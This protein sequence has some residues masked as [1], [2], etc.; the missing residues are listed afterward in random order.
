MALRGHENDKEHADPP[1]NQEM[2]TFM[3]NLQAMM[4]ANEAMMRDLKIDLE[5]KMESQR[6]QT[7][8]NLRQYL[9]EI[10]PAQGG[11]DVAMDDVEVPPPPLG[12][13]NI[14][15]R[16][17]PILPIEEVADNVN[18]V[19]RDE[20][21]AYV[22]PRVRG[23]GAGNG[24][25]GNHNGHGHNGGRNGGNGNANGTS[26][27]LST[28]EHLGRFPIQCG[29]ANTGFQ[30]LRL[31]PNSLT[32][33]AFTWYINLPPN[34]VTT[35]EEMERLFH[36]QFYKTEPEISMVDLSRLSQRKGE[37]AED[38][39]ARFKKMRNRCRIALP[40]QEFVR[41]A[42]NGLDLELRKKFEGMEFRDYYEMSTKVARY[43]R[44]LHEEMERRSSSYGTYY[45]EPNYEL[46]VAEIK[47]DRPIECPAL[48]SD[49]FDYLYKSG[50]VKLPP[51]HNIPYLEIIKGKEYCK[52]HDSW[53]HSTN[54][55]TVFRNI[56]QEKIE[57]GILKF[58]EPS[59]KDMG[60]D[61]NPFPATVNMVAINFPK[62]GRLTKEEKAKEVLEEGQAAFMKKKLVV[63]FDQEPCDKPK[64]QRYGYANSHKID[65]VPNQIGRPI[66][67]PLALNMTP[68]RKM[69]L[70]PPTARHVISRAENYLPNK[71]VPQK[72]NFDHDQGRSMH[73]EKP[74]NQVAYASTKETC[75]ANPK[76]KQTAPHPMVPSTSKAI[77]SNL[78]VLNEN[79]KFP[80]KPRSKCNDNIDGAEEGNSNDVHP[81]LKVT[82]DMSFE[83]LVVARLEPLGAK[84]VLEQARLD[85]REAKIKRKEV[86]LDIRTNVLAD[87]IIALN[88]ARD[89]FN[90]QKNG[91]VDQDKVDNKEDDVNVVDLVNALCENTS[92]DFLAKS[93]DS[94]TFGQFTINLHCNV[95]TLPCIFAAK[96]DEE[97]DLSEPL[98]NGDAEDEIL[99]PCK[100]EKCSGGKDNEAKAITFLKPNEN[101]TRHIKPLY[102]KAHFDG[103]PLNRIL[104]DNGAAVNLLPYASLRKLGKCADD[105]IK[106]DVTVSD[107]FGAVSKTRGILPTSLTVGSETSVSALFVV[108]SSTY[109]ALLDKDWIHSN[110]CVPS[111]LHQ[112]LMFWNDNEVEIVHADN[113]P[114]KVESNA[115]EARYYDES[116]GT[117]WFLGQ[118]KYGRPMPMVST[119]TLEKRIQSLED[120]AA[121]VANAVYQNQNKIQDEITIQELDHAPMKLDD[122]KAE[123]Q[124]PLL[125][126]DLGTDGKHRPPYISQL[127][128]E[129]DK[130]R[131]VALLKEYKD[132]F[133]WDYDEMPGLSRDLVE[134]RLPIIEGYRPY[135][136]PP[137][138]MANNVILLVKE[139]IERLIKVD[140][141]VLRATPKD[142]YP[143]PVAD[144]LV[145]GAAQDKILSFMDG[146]SGYNQIFI[147]EEDVSKTAFRCPGAIGTFEW[148]VM[149]FDL[150]NARATYQRAMNAIFHDMIGKFMEV[151]IDDV[152]VKSHNSLNH[153]N[154]LRRSFERMRHH[155]LK[156]NPLKCAFG[157]SA[158]NFL[159]F[160]VHQRGIEIDQ[161]KARAIMQAQPPTNKKELQR[162]L[163]QINFLKRF[164]AN[165][166]GKTKAFSPLLKLK[167]GEEFVWREEHQVAF[168][169]IKKY[170][171]MPP[172]L[173]P[174]RKEKPLYLY[175]SA[176][177]SSIGCLLAQEVERGKEQVVYYLSQTLTD[178]ENRYSPIEKLCLSLYFAAIKLRHYMLYYNVCIIAK[179]DIVKYMLTRPILRGRLGK[180]CFALLEFSFRYIPQKAIKGQAVA[181]FS[182]DHPCLDLGEDFEEAMEVMEI[183]TLPWILEF[184]GSS[185]SESNGAG[186]VITSP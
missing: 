6:T 167:D 88:K 149:P 157:V 113:K 174:P 45:H 130:L 132:C 44:L 89:E 154:H 107:Y 140:S 29:E 168:E 127:L 139:E 143:M 109:H 104:V 98:P 27:D 173:V 184:D 164:I 80:T 146:H 108:D 100:S 50:M 150:K 155:G 124:D 74:K 110:W 92:D 3:A 97:M 183:S 181:D 93:E 128:A 160:L 46:G 137:R 120:L 102:I 71:N 126:I 30:K 114:F 185:T 23:N 2:F 138:R 60:V 52:Y 136:H 36:T 47:T 61:K 22:P 148:V 101:A 69:E 7:E 161:N 20:V 178:V 133:A 64:K 12:V 62:D 141:S 19:N 147:V 103:I 32:G 63:H 56:V 142:Q 76:P 31:F 16:Q 37:S 186:I 67:R 68:R 115:V 123:V 166:A 75:F 86:E 79:V 135:Q 65:F 171:A 35:W 26:S 39:I 131:I 129:E 151:Y 8:D 9:R 34:S 94:I 55:C 162:F 121:P 10:I 180:W 158:G 82:H 105:L 179:T 95:L 21:A 152:V 144:V 38:Y 49:V 41:L 15:E 111:S 122:L 90:R 28:V 176:T 70:T 156:M 169:A 51:G 85:E 170:L 119:Y 58:P 72:L 48:T 54:S 96:V 125:E 91:D 83:Q 81:M 159:G 11:I 4:Q 57:R 116:V 153:I 53:R 17:D 175:V 106:S 14:Q 42:Q 59:K 134:H 84:V 99:L 118:D 87:M 117:I 145:D 40:E 25:H 18:E 13:D 182:A 165:T 77:P 5:R 73:N 163:G 24:H 78:F 66:P 172:V 177:L 1:E 33:V 112:F 43:E